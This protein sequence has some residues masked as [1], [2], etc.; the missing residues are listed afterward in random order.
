MMMEHLFG[1]IA[2]E[3]SQSGGSERSSFFNIFCEKP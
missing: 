2:F 1:I 3:G